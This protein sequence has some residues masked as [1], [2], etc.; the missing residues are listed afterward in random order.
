METKSNITEQVG[1]TMTCKR[2][3]GIV[4]RNLIQGGFIARIMGVDGKVIDI[5]GTKTERVA[6]K[7]IARGLGM[8]ELLDGTFA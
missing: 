7:W 5:H 2:G 4:S 1:E 8:V 6:R 3:T